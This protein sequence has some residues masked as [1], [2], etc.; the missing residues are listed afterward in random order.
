MCNSQSEELYK[1]VKNDPNN[2]WV[3]NTEL[4]NQSDLNSNNKDKLNELNNEFSSTSATLKNIIEEIKKLDMENIELDS[5]FKKVELEKRKSL[6]T[7]RELEFENSQENNPSELLPFYDEMERLKKEQDEFVRKSQEQRDEANRISKLIE[8]T[9]L[10]N[11]QSFSNLFSV[12]ANKF[13]GVECK[14]T[15]EKLGNDD[16]KKFY[17]IID[18]STRESEFELSESQRFFIDHAFRMSI[19]S[20][21]YTTPTFYIVETPDSSLDLS[22]EKNAAD[23]FSSFLN[24]PYSLIITSNLNNSAFVNYIMQN[25]EKEKAVVRLFEIA[26]KS[27]IQENNQELLQLYNSITNG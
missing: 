14:L 23:V 17:P 10:K 27:T 6:V 24:K 19:L 18:G 1:K 13:L 7:L 2:C 9:V 25:D 5:N 26:K 20:H 8:D 12:F 3:C 22:Y 15:Y 21:F 4:I 11:V 16:L